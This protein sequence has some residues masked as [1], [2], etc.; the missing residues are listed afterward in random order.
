M[1]ALRDRL[2]EGGRRVVQSERMVDGWRDLVDQVQ[3]EGSDVTA[4]RSLL[5]TFQARRK[6]A[7]S[8]KRKRRKP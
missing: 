3:V 4:A 2:E 5:E 1:H 6:A 7:I 8:D